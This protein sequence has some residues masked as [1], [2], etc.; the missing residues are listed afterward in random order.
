MDNNKTEQILRKAVQEATP[1]VNNTQQILEI[2]KVL[3]FLLKEFNH[4][5]F[6]VQAVVST[7]LEKALITSEEI[8]AKF[9]EI[10]IEHNQHVENKLKEMQAQQEEAANKQI[11]IID[12]DEEKEAANEIE[13]LR[14]ELINEQEKESTE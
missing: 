11:T 3:E 5:T 6:S 1:Y 2:Q 8:E 9:K 7:L 12:E 13:K 14:Q 10:V 4:V